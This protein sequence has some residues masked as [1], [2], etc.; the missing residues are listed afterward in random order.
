MNG[1]AAIPALKGEHG[2]PVL[3]MTGHA[4]EGFREDA[5]CFGAVGLVEKPLEHDKLM[6]IVHGVSS[7]ARSR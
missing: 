6:N 5:V 4:D 3:V 1:F 7:L 2:V